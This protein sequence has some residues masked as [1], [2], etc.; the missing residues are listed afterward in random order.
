MPSRIC[1][2]L[3]GPPSSRWRITPPRSTKNVL[4]RVRTP[5]R[6]VVAPSVS[7]I[8]RRRS[9]PS[10][11]MKEGARWG[12]PGARPAWIRGGRAPPRGVLGSSDQRQEVEE[13]RQ[14]R[15]LARGEDEAHDDDER[16]ASEVDRTDVC[17]EPPRQLSRAAE[18]PGD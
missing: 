14:P 17:G 15:E 16:T 8:G 10:W 9:N 5:K 13:L 3:S 12:F 7:R 6:R 1:S 18:A 2:S 11:S 4:G